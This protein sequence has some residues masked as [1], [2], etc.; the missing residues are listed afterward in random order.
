MFDAIKA[1]FAP[2]VAAIRAAVVVLILAAVAISSWYIRGTIAASEISALKLQYAQEQTEHADRSRKDLISVVDRSNSLQRTIEGVSRDQQSKERS[3]ART[4][5]MLDS[6]LTGLR[7][8]YAEAKLGR[9]A[10]AGE[11]ASARQQLEAS[12]ATGV[13]FTPDWRD[14]LLQEAAGAL[15]D[16][17]P[18]LQTSHERHEALTAFYEEARRGIDD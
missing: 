13:V 1:T 9:E 14:E 5:A 16:L 2:Y 15:R 12:A 6:Q 8:K 11:A 10:A 4:V 17:A 7:T 18:A 3:H